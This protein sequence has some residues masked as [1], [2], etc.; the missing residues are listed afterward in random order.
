MTTVPINANVFV[1]LDGSGNGTAKLGPASAREIWNPDNVH[2]QVTGPVTNEASC[3][4]Y[5]GDNATQGNFRDATQSG[6]T[7]DSSGRVNADTIKSGHYV[8]AVW[9]GGDAGRQATLLVTGS[10]TV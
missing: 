10:R 5:V 2:V 7:G 4:I 1:I 6:S 9:A 8:W 3:I